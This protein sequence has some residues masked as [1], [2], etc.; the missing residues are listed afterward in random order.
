MFYSK[1]NNGF[2]A[3]EIHG[4]A[5]PADAVEITDAEHA[6][7][8]EGQSQGQRI[9]ADAGGFPVLADPLPPTA[10]QV[11][12][13]FSAAIQARLDTF[14]RTRNYDGILSASTYATST[15]PKFAAE[16]Q[17]AVNLRDATWAA[18]YVILAAVE[19]GTRAMPTLE[20]VMAELPA[21]VWPA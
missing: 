7:L 5:I 1:S 15:V 9:A 4:D 14:A 6:A 12:S 13:A 2:Y 21:L 20:A 19:A 10:E 17:A 3:I 8:L 16:G 18:A 11:Q